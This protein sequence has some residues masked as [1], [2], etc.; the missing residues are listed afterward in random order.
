MGDG[1]SVPEWRGQATW[2]A[3]SHRPEVSTPRPQSGPGS[4]C[5]APQPGLPWGDKWISHLH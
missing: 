1:G 4:P 2:E 5:A 3:G